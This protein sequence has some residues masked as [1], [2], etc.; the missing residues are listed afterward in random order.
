MADSQAI[1]APFLGM[2]LLTAFVWAYMYTRRL[3]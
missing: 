2:L 1:L 3:T